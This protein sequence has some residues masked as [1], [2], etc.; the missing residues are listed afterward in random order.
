[1][2]P[3]LKTAFDDSKIALEE[4]EL[5]LIHAQENQIQTPTTREPQTVT[6]ATAVV[7]AAV[8]AHDIAK[9]RFENSVQE[10]IDKN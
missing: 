1:M 8:Q 7:N 3:G 2:R 4:A 5:Q 10:Q 6:T 9:Q